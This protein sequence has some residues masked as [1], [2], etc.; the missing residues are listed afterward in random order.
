MAAEVLRI[1]AEKALTVL[2]EGVIFIGI[3]FLLP[4]VY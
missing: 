4:N 2:N 1:A 3:S